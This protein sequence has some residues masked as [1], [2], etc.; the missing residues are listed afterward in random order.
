MYFFAIQIC[1]I[2]HSAKDC[3]HGYKCRAK[4]SVNC[5]GLSQGSG[6]EHSTKCYGPVFFIGQFAKFGPH[7]HRVAELLGPL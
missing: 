6:C 3:D 5:S 1:G 2:D 4:T 7:G